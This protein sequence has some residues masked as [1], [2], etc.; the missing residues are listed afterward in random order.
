M[1]KNYTCT[2]CSMNCSMT[3]DIQG[4]RVASLKGNCC[5]RGITF[6]NQAMSKPTCH[7]DMP[8]QSQ[9]SVSRRKKVDW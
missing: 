1:I 8:V 4:A 7:V 2:L 3:A 5:S 9:G 6:V